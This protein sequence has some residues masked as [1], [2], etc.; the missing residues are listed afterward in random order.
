MET[1]PG[2]NVNTANPNNPNPQIQPNGATPPVF[3]APGAKKAPSG[4]MD[5][6]AFSQ[7]LTKMNEKVKYNNGLMDMRNKL[8]R[9]MYDTPLQAEE[10]A[11]LTPEVQDAIKNGDKRRLEMELRLTN[12]QIQGRTS[13]L[14]SSM[15]FLGNSYKDTLSLLDKQRQDA[16]DNVLKFAQVYGS[17]AKTALKSLYGQ[18][19]ID[20]LKE[21]GI[22]IDAFGST[23]TLEQI[24]QG[25]A[26]DTSA[27]PKAPIATERN[28]LSFFQRMLNATNNLE[29][30]E[31]T[32]SKLKTGGRFLLSNES[33]IANLFKSKE[34]QQYNQAQ[35]EFTEARLRKESGA[36]IPDS[37]FEND[38]KTYFAQPGDKP[39]QLEIKRKAREQALRGLG[40]SS[41][42][43][44][45][46]FYGY[47]PSKA[48]QSANFRSIVGLKGSG[49]SEDTFS[50][51]DAGSAPV[52]SIIDLGN[53]KQV[54]KIGD[55]EYEDL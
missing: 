22:D 46:E 27:P 20:A 4:Y 47:N 28:N 40:T 45:W 24:K 10:L 33:K 29:G 50:I 38:K 26:G 48:V 17:E 31:S 52:G 51:S 18:E 41:G 11:T 32:I 16:V 6:F 30:V 44:F 21:Q 9:Q 35:R 8:I 19:Y 36:A 1:N 43:A 15:K 37:E 13:S 5:P 42:N 7:V 3:S 55:D 39:E 25:A 53:G 12:D 49:S 23:P 54:K 2:N 14:D 34:M